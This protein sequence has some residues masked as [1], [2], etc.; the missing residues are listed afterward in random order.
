MILYPEDLSVGLLMKKKVGDAVEEGDVLA[1]IH[2]ASEEKA[3]EAVKMLQKCY[4]I[5]SEAPEAKPFIRG[6]LA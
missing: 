6:T 3:Q 4:T 5:S 1:E 2:A